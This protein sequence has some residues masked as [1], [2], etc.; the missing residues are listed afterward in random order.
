MPKKYQI[1][2]FGPIY[3]GFE[4]KPKQAIQHLMKVKQ[5]ECPRA[6]Y[7]SDIGYVDIVWGQNDPKTNKGYGLKHIIE[8][9]GK[10]IN[11]M[12]FNVEDFIPIVF[13]YGE[14]NKKKSTN[15]RKVYESNRFRFVI[16]CK[17]KGKTKTWL[18]TAFVIKKGSKMSP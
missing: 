8:K 4:G 18:L 10:D 12:G 6:L 14:F 9:H 5:G 2:E 3:I 1:G 16:E 17:Y 11:E 7:R 13:Q 15:D